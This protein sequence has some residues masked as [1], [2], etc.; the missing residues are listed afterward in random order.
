MIVSMN[1]EIYPDHFSAVF[2][3]L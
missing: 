1:I 2:L 3:Q